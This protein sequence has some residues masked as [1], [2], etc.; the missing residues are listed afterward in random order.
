MV[1]NLG[2]FKLYLTIGCLYLAWKMARDTD[3]SYGWQD[4]ATPFVWAF[5]IVTWPFF[6]ILDCIT[7][8]L[9]LTLKGS[10]DGKDPF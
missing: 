2:F 10:Q 9:I 6:W 7:L 1:I 8:A 3:G 4:W 5:V